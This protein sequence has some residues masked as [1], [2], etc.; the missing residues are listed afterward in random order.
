M[1]DRILSNIWRGL[2]NFYL[3]KHESMDLYPVE[4]NSQ[5]IK[6]IVNNELYIITVKKG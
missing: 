3:E 2:S 1:I 6:I 5:E 4:Y